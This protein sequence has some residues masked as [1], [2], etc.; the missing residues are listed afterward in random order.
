MVKENETNKKDGIISDVDQVRIDELSHDIT[1]YFKRNKEEY[2]LSINI[3]RANEGKIE[4]HAQNDDVPVLMASSFTNTVM[5]EKLLDQ[6]RDILFDIC[7]YTDE[8]VEEYIK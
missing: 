4:I 1:F 6:A 3:N 2:R 5:Y 8:I 7:Q